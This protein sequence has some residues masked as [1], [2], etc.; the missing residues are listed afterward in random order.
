MLTCMV[1]CAGCWN[2]RELNEL[3]I[4]VGTAID[5]V[6]DQYQVA[7][8]VVVPGEVTP[9]LSSG[10]APV[11]LYKATAPTIFEAFRKLTETSPRKIYSAH[12]RTLVIGE[13]L[14]RE[15]IANV[16]D[17]LSRNPEAR[18]D[19][20]VV[21]SRGIPAEDTL[22]VLTS[23]EKI[24]AHNLFYSIDTSSKVWSPT[25][26]ITMDEIIDQMV[27][28]G[29]NLVLPGV[30]RIGNT[31]K[32]EQKSNVEEIE[33]SSHLRTTGL[34]MFKKDKLIGWLN[35][36]EGRGYNYIRNNVK[37]SVGHLDCPDGGKIAL[38][39]LR[40][41]TTMK[42]QMVKG[43]PVIHIKINNQSNIGEV[44]CKIDITDPNTIS[45]IE[46]QVQERIKQ[47]M[48]KVIA[49]VQN[50]Y[51]VDIFGFGQAIYKSDPKAWKRIKAVW[52]SYFS[53]LKVEYEIQV[54]IRRTGTTNNSFK[55]YLKE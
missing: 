41:D 9:R 21:V 35:E 8:Q 44:E 51:H 31:K 30:R 46:Q 13:P 22:K 36:D 25:T 55:N 33:P 38:E 50:N 15:G 23:L 27:S 52:P 2:R 42:G 28:E 18:T 47:L 29:T 5:K 49:K 45:W 53:K 17:L 14:A 37:S 6:G 19:Y 20:Y 11:T 16:L 40:S 54:T 10:R 7:V 4:Q 32:G 3:G 12:I 1:I 26:A 24:P 34:A 39:T 48:Q 43:E